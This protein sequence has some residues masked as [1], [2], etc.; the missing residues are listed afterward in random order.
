MF[1]AIAVVL[2]F[3]AIL[4]LVPVIIIAILIIAAAGLTRGVDMFALLGLGSL[5]G[6]GGRAGGGVGRAGTGKGIS[7]V[8]YSGNVIARGKAIKKAGGIA[9]FSKAGQRKAKSYGKSKLSGMLSSMRGAAAAKRTA[10]T[11]LLQRSG[12]RMA[13]PQARTPTKT[14]P[15]LAAQPGRLTFNPNSKKP[16]SV[17]IP[18]AASALA[19][20]AAAK[21]RSQARKE[22]KAIRSGEDELLQRLN[23]S[24]MAEYFENKRKYSREAKSEFYKNEKKERPE[25]E[26]HKTGQQVKEERR[27]FRE[28]RES[29]SHKERNES[30]KDAYRKYFWGY[31]D[32]EK[33][34]V[35]GVFDKGVI[36]SGLAQWIRASRQKAPPTLFDNKGKDGEKSKEEEKQNKRQETK[37]KQ[38]LE[39]EEQRRNENKERA[40]KELSD[41]ERKEQEQKKKGNDEA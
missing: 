23:P 6:L 1:G 38:D 19:L 32:P 12:V 20:S 11:N 22:K 8:K 33:G 27:K 25:R 2:S 3:N 40:Q 37:G 10:Q 9:A 13:V 35:K 21:S 26:A 7:G 29:L 4:P 16:S 14:Y 30:Y 5:I 36:A 17:Y 28:Q 15:R 41:Q 31:N 18:L 39:A 24:E 34:P